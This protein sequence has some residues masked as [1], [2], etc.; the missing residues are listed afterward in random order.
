MSGLRFRQF[1]VELHCEESVNGSASK[2]V[3]AKA[4]GERNRQ[5]SST[6]QSWE[7]GMRR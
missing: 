7:A 3:L 5:Q 2:Q 4:E 1:W 6:G